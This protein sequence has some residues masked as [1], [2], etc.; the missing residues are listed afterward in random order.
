[1]IY[2]LYFLFAV[3]WLAIPQVVSAVPVVQQVMN[4]ASNVSPT[5][6]NGSLA[7][8]SIFI[9]K[10]TGLGPAALIVAPNP[11]QSTT[12]GGTS[13]AVTI[14][15]TRVDALMYYTSDKQIA[16]LLPS[17]VPSGGGTITVTYNGSASTATAI[18]GVA[19]NNLGI[20][21]ID[22]TGGGP[23][24][25]TYADYSLVSPFRAPNCSGPNT[26]CGAAN[27]GDTLILWGTGL[28]AVSGSD[29]TGAGLGQNMPN[30]PLQL[31]VGGAMAQIVY[32]GRSGCC[33]GEDQ[34]VFTVPTT[35]ATGC[36]VP[37]MARIANQVSNQVTIPIAPRGRTCLTE[38][39]GV[40]AETLTVPFSFGVVELDH[41][42]NDNGVGFRDE[43][44]ITFARI[45]SV[46]PILQPYVAAMQSEHIAGTCIVENGTEVGFNAVLTDA[47]LLDGGSSFAIRGPNGNLTVQGGSGNKVPLGTSGS[48]MVPGSY[49]ITSNGGRD[50]GPFT[51][52]LTLPPTPSLLTP[53]RANLTL[54]RAQGLTVTWNPNGSNGQVE[55][56][57][58][59]KD[60]FNVSTVNVICTAPASAGTFTIPPYATLA[61]PTTS[62]AEFRFQPGDHGPAA[63][64]EFT[65]SGLSFGI[66]QIFA[67]NVAFAG[68]PVN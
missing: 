67:G 2:F 23:G 6:P 8:G 12:L 34:I 44:N 37:L 39:P 4:A 51:A 32:Q 29:A 36:A 62:N 26:T 31:W 43:A 18:R 16:A 55:I 35:A 27:P 64:S 57:L 48:F 38:L 17:N 25:V 41:F 7:P 24:I 52:N 10:G 14:G 21:T 56:Q 53:A 46:P 33:I 1:M 66:A 45:P 61:L 13:V 60:S 49:T 40:S 28:G 5:L 50:V 19:A 9:V 22:S 47:A 59:A 65:A 42:L 63:Q 58:S 54:N 20:F 68:I 3:G 11:F 30:V 15:S